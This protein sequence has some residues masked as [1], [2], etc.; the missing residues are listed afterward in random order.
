[1]N[2]VCMQCASALTNLD[3]MRVGH[4]HLQILYNTFQNVMLLFHCH[5]VCKPARILDMQR[6]VI[7]VYRGVCI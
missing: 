2:I 7:Y 4:I 3:A 1:M 5:Q 6:M